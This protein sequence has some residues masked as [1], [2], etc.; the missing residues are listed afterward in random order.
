MIRDTARCEDKSWKDAVWN[1]LSNITGWLLSLFASLSESWPAGRVLDKLPSGPLP[2]VPVPASL[3]SDRPAVELGYDLAFTANGNPLRG[4]G[5]YSIDKQV[6]TDEAEPGACQKA[7]VVAGDTTCA[8]CTWFCG[9]NWCYGY[10]F[11]SPCWQVNAAS[12]L[13]HLGQ[14]RRQER[15]FLGPQNIPGETT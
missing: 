11:L 2:E 9:H 4:R 3:L 10:A 15:P 5:V 14:G 12:Q 13:P 6:K 7:T 8:V 1:L